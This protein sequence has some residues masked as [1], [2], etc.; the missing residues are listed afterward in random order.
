MYVNPF[1]FGVITTLAAELILSVIA[2]A[3]RSACED[4]EDDM[5]EEEFRKILTETTGKQFK[6]TLHDG[7]MVGE[8]IEDKDDDDSDEKPD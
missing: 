4:E 6:V 2:S 3:I 7:Y 1:W 5:S 8:P